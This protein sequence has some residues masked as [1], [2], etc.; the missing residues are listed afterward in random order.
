[1]T[2]RK[3]GIKEDFANF[4]EEPDRVKF[5]ELIKNN[6]GEYNHID[7]K[8]QWI[9]GPSLARHILG[10]A[11]TGGGIIVFGVKENEDKSLESIG[12]SDLID[13]TVVISGVQSFIPEKL[14][15]DIH[16][17]SF[18]EAEYAAIKGK[19][20]VLIVEDTPEYLPFLSLRD[21]E[22]IHRNKVY[23]RGSVNTDEASHEQLQEII[24]RR[25]ETGYSSTKE[26]EFRDHLN[27]LKDLYGV[28]SR[29]HSSIPW[30]SSF[31]LAGLFTSTPNPNYPSEDFEKFVVRMIE[32]KKLIIDGLVS[33]RGR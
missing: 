26:M 9:E 21:G 28:I 31:G 30:L 14:N 25:I 7:F 1:M 3:K 20:Q 6:T 10:F 18:T 23:Y 16:D 33:G 12:L 19:F 24:N 13:K 2:E 8:E 4:F 22:N 17:F 15:F 11:N 5:R 29:I 27:Q 32:K